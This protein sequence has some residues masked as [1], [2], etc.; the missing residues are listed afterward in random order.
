M[1]ITKEERK[2]IF[3]LG[4]SYAKQY[5]KDGFFNDYRKA[6][7]LGLKLAYANKRSAEN[8]RKYGAMI[9][10]DDILYDGYISVYTKYNAKFVHEIH[11]V[12]GARWNGACWT[13]PIKE[14]GKVRQ[15]LREVY[16]VKEP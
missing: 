2:R 16:G 11:T 15:I 4:H 14:V 8:R 5:I 7:K 3:R 13:A 9:D 12:K 6:F 1:K 10:L